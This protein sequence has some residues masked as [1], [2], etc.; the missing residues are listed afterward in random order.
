M[1][2]PDRAPG[3]YGL[4][5]RDP[6]RKVPILEHY[7][8]PW[9]GPVTH[10]EPTP[11]L[12]GRRVDAGASPMPP[13]E[14]DIDR[15]SRVGDWPMYVNGPDPSNPA[16][17]K[18]GLGD[19]FWAGSGH[20]FTALRVYAG[21]PET[22]FSDAVIVTGYQ[23]TGYQPGK[24]GTDQ[25]TDPAQ[26]FKYLSTTGLAGLDGNIHTVAGYAFFDDPTN[27]ALMAQVLNTFGTVGVGFQCTQGFEEAFNDGVPCQYQPGDQPVGG[28]WVILQRRGVGGVGVLYEITWGA[29]QQVTRRYN[30][31]QVT[32][33]VAI[34]SADWIRANGTTVQGLD[35]EQL[36]E[37]TADAE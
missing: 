6:D 4:L 11:Q 36:C 13:A 26:G 24:P 15:L 8:R 28:H 16:Y 32:D 3:L 17:A 12:I 19:C 34:A 25:G 23:S 20:M 33:A 29:V 9:E 14:G 31:H 18:D 21:F 27:T 2:N 30:W 10:P 37:D 22:H 35:L 7:L 1:S 5:P